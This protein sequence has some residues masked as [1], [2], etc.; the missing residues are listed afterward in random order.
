MARKP[1]CSNN[2]ALRT[3]YAPGITRISGARTSSRSLRLLA[4]AAAKISLDSV[5]IR[6][7]LSLVE[8]LC[9]SRRSGLNHRQRAETVGLN[10]EDRIELAAEVLQGND[11][12]QLHQLF[13]RKV[14]LKPLEE[15]IRNSFTRVSHPLRQLQRQPL[16]GREKRIL[17]VISQHRLHLFRRCPILH[18]TGCIDVNSERTPI[19]IRC[20]DAQQVAHLAVDESRGQDSLGNGLDSFLD[21]RSQGVH[22]RGIR[23]ETVALLLLLKDS[24]YLLRS[25]FLRDTFDS[26]HD[27]LLQRVNPVSRTYVRGF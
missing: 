21:R 19:D 12:R 24:P 6:D 10:A 26:S 3:S 4:L 16:A 14:M 17:P 9:G 27:F 2:R 11:R 20:L 18:R 25:I 5:L 22:P 23:H 1:S 15:P 7:F 13:I 8:P